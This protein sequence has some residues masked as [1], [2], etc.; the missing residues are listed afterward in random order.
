MYILVY[1]HNIYIVLIH[2]CTHYMDVLKTK[3]KHCA[4]WPACW[5]IYS[6]GR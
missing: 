5:V 6:V 3:Q 1:I 2:I 4:K